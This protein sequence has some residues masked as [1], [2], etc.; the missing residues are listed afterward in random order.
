MYFE[1]IS[2]PD[3]EFNYRCEDE[4]VNQF[5]TEIIYEAKKRFSLNY[6]EVKNAL[7]KTGIWDVVNDTDLMLVG[8]TEGIE[9]VMKL[10]E[11]DLK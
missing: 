10:I 1:Y 2:I 4:I 11:G 8:A 7:Q 3:S 6:L 9:P 5:V